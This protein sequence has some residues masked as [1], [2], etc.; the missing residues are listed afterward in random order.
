[1]MNVNEI[2]EDVF[3][4]FDEPTANGGVSKYSQDDN[5]LV[6]RIIN[7]VYSDICRKTGCSR[8]TYSFNTVPGQRE[9]SMPED[10]CGIKKVIY[11]RFPLKLIFE[12]R[13]NNFVG[14]PVSYYQR[15][16]GD[17]VI[18]GIDPLPTQAYWTE[19]SYYVRPTKR[20][21]GTDVPELVPSDYHWLISYGTVAELF[22]I[23]K[24]DTSNGFVKWS[25]LYQ[26][27]IDEL[28]QYI[29]NG[30]NGDKYPSIR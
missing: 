28:K 5:A 6:T 2:I 27:G 13:A 17:M 4:L 10:C 8:A 21:S 16:S 26:S 14:V 19:V 18:V 7:R 30:I 15:Q 23:D 22:K 11:D 1:M 20:I 25:G 29:R 24:G 9:Y 12:N 3:D